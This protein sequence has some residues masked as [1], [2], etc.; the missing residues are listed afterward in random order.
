[1]THPI[2]INRYTDMLLVNV[3]LGSAVKRMIEI[4]MSAYP[5]CWSVED[6]REMAENYLAM[7][8]GPRFRPSD[9]TPSGSAASRFNRYRKGEL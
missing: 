6:R 3:Q 4:Q 1:M 8:N 7:P 9:R 5:E 2:P